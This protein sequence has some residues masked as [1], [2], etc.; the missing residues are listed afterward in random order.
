MPSSSSGPSSAV[1]P[2]KKARRTPPASQA[3][4]QPQPGGPITLA[5]QLLDPRG[6]PL[7]FALAGLVE[8]ALTRWAKKLVGAFPLCFNARWIEVRRASSSRLERGEGGEGGADA[9][10]ACAQRVSGDLAAQQSVAGSLR[11]MLALDRPG[12]GQDGGQA[13][14]LTSVRPSLSSSTRSDGI[15]PTLLTPQRLSKHLSSTY[16]TRFPPAGS[17]S[18]AAGSSPP[19]LSLIDPA[20]LSPPPSPPLTPPAPALLDP[21]GALRAAL[22]L[23]GTRGVKPDAWAAPARREEGGEGEG[24]T[25]GSRGVRGARG[26]AKKGRGGGARGA[27]RGGA[28]RTSLDDDDDD[29]L[30]DDVRPFP[31]LTP[32]LELRGPSSER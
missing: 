7:H 9:L 13:A 11:R 2:R 28:R 32:P 15:L 4:P 30:L 26:A 25:A 8:A 18:P 20:L 24:A 22:L 3:P 1:R 14:G 5:A 17:P 16:P 21:A 12:E 23:L 6:A 19:A 29:L 10:G 27:R 31:P